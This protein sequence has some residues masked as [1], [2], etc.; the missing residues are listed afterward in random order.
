MGVA[1][2]MLTADYSIF[3]ISFTRNFFGFLPILLLLAYSKQFGA[4]KTP[5]S[6]KEWSICAVRGGSVSLAQLCL[7]MAYS[8]L[9]FAT[10]ATL[11]FSGPFF[12]TGLSVPLLGAV[13]GFWRW[14]AVI[15]GFCGVVM[16]MQPGASIFSLFSILPVLAAL[17]YA[18]SSTLV[19]I[20]S[21]DRLS[22]VI[23]LRS[24][25]FTAGFSLLLWVSFGEMI[26]IASAF[27]LGLF[28]ALGL[29]GGAG[30]LGLV[31]AYRMSQ[32]SLLA[33]FEYFGIPFSMFLGWWFF[34]EA[35]LD[36][37][38]PG[39]LAIIGGGF[40]IIWRQARIK[41]DPAP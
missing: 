38:F 3:Q 31:V 22:G 28:V 39:V 30:V 33:P 23:Q 32:P 29:L 34:A 25:I 1:V 19:K 12:V 26:P 21:V 41:A 6:R 5:F 9:E 13:V 7:F 8:K 36:R 11:A 14:S 27:D 20:F 37:L 10:V 16:I 40:I 24:Q 2:R 35:P 17:F 15:L 4:L 18:M